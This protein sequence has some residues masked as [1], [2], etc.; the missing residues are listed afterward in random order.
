MLVTAAFMERRT[1]LTGEKTVASQMSV[2]E[3]LTCG[4]RRKNNHYKMPSYCLVT[5]RNQE[6][7]MRDDDAGT[8]RATFGHLM[9]LARC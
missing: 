1:A 5:T 8:R 3:E 7:A 2:I 6:D 4:E 9:A